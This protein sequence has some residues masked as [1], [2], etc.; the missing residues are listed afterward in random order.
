[1][2]FRL[3]IESSLFLLSNSKHC[4][5]NTVTSDLKHIAYTITLVT[6][7]KRLKNYHSVL[8]LIPA[9]SDSNQTLNPYNNQLLTYDKSYYIINISNC[10]NL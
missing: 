1:M 2:V 5:K 7:H 6:N 8:K 4:H 9:H 3:D 10:K